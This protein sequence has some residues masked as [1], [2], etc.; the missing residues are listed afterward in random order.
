[1]NRLAP[2]D[3]K[4][5]VSDLKIDGLRGRYWQAPALSKRASARTLV[6]VYGHHS[7]LERN[8]GLAQYLRRFGR[9]LIPDLPG[10]GG[11]DSFYETGRLPTLDNYADYLKAFLDAE[12]DKDKP[13]VLVGFSLGFL[14]ATRFLQRHPAYRER[15]S[16]AVSVAGFVKHDCLKFDPGRRCFYLT[17]ANTVRTKLG[18]AVFRRLLLNRWVLR[19]F[20]ARTYSA[21]HKFAGRSPADRERFL[22]MEVGLWHLN[23]SRT[24]A[25]T[26]KEMLTCDLTGKRLKLPLFHL[27][28][29]GDQFLDAATNLANL[30]RIYNKVE[31]L[32]VESSAHAPSVIASAEEIEAIMPD[33]MADVV[34][35]SFKG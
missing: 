20:Y 2:D 28:V 35:R 23:D 13:V 21:R 17:V 5:Y 6:A 12:L 9:V 29:A 15:V 31:V 34:R 26:A 19:R 8:L 22:K 24:W 14:I 16:S 4:D 18:A 3:F 10:F 7:S 25:F 11:M 33:D 30:K 1:M 27:D 32:N